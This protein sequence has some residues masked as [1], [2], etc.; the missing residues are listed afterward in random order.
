VK[1]GFLRQFSSQWPLAVAAAFCVYS[2][3]LLINAFQSQ[4]QL[5]TEADMRI[6]A[7]SKRRAAAVADLI[8]ERRNGTVDLAEAHEV[9]NYFINKALGM[10]LRYGLNANLYAIEERFRN[11]LARANL[12]GE[13]IYNRVVLYDEAR[14]VLVDL[15][16]DK[17][18]FALPVDAGIKPAVLFDPDLRRIVVSAPVMFKGAFSGIVA[19]VGELGQLSRDLIPSDATGSYMEVLVSA[20]GRELPAYGT[21]ARISENLVQALAELPANQP[22]PT[23]NLPGGNS[24]VDTGL[25]V[26]SQ[27]PGSDLSLVTLLAEETVY[28]QVTSRLFLYSA[29]VIPLIMLVAA[30]MFERVRRVEM[31]LARSEQRFRTIFNNIRDAIIILHMDD[32]AVLEANPRMLSMFGYGSSEVA[33]LTP[34]DISENLSPYDPP[35][36]SAR[37][38]AAAGGEPQFFPWRARRKNGEAFWVEISMLRASIDGRERLLAVAHDITQRKSQEQE[39]LAAL[40]YQRQLNTRLEDTQNQLLQSEKMASIGQ[41]AAGVA[42]EI[43]NPVGYVHSNMNTLQ[44]YVGGFLELLE[45]YGEADA[46]IAEPNAAMERAR[47]KRSKMDMAFLKEDVASLFAETR[48]GI[49]RVIKIVKD[50]KDFSHVDNEEKWAREDLHK[51]LESTLNVIWNELKYK[52]EIKKE[53]GDLPLVECLIFQLNQVFMNILV[54][55][56][57]AIENKGTITIRTGTKGDQVWIEIADNGKGIAA[58]NLKRIFDPFFTTKPVGQGTGLGLS[59]S[60]SII[61]KHHG[62]IDVESQEGKGTTFRVNLPVTQSAI[63]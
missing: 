9:A 28:G 15:A 26:R 37:M 50:L 39:L 29:S 49:E 44:S 48:Q 38:T 13:R 25:A 11:Q 46:T 1:V 57:H 22:T 12:R 42:H 2:L 17:G 30:F 20:T 51:G 54:N 33:G 18:E 21:P 24:F 10:S 6:V 4:A 59:V 31:A 7:D 36:W 58:E 52:C 32:G 40:E 61:K 47:A 53:Y 19:T 14:R 41:L 35:A 3:V 8:A 27:I 16:P 34:A 45:A 55:A 60:Y 5:R 56:S 23:G 63:E 43:N 62:S